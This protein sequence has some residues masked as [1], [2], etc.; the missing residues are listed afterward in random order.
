V[1]ASHPSSPTPHLQPVALCPVFVVTVQQGL[2]TSSLFQ[3]NLSILEYVRAE[4][5]E[6]NDPS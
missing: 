1:G 3:L 4:E 6:R 5:L 2:T